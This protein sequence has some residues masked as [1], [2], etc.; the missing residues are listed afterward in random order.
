MPCAPNDSP[1]NQVSAWRHVETLSSLVEL[2]VN[3]TRIVVVEG[4]IAELIGRPV[5]G[6]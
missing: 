4:N 3:A 2:S 6:V 1:T 5:K